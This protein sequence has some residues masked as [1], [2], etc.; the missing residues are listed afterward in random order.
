MNRKAVA[1]SP[2]TAGTEEARPPDAARERQRAS[3]SR[4]RV[5]RRLAARLKA[6]R[7][8]RTV[9][10]AVALVPLALLLVPAVWLVHHVYFDRTGVPD[11]ES[12]LRFEPPT[13]GV[14]RDARGE[15]LIE[16]AREYRRVVTYDEVP[17][18]LRQAIL[19]AED[20]RFFTHSGVDYRALPRV[21]QKTVVRSV[22]EWRKGGHGLRLLLPQ[23]GSTLTQQLVRGYFLQDL[24]GRLNGDALFHAGLAPPRL[25]SVV[26]GA[27]AT[28]KLLRKLEEVRLTL[29]L[30]EEMRRR[31][32]SQGQ[33][34]REIFARY[35]S[36]I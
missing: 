10:L 34:K 13:I 16:L 30:E 12:F 11:L 35:A 26:L 9:L 5:A 32:G 4:L 18:I 6:M 31:Y 29:W 8:R 27:S 7:R 3:F 23:G 20:K 1:L 15:V 24:T 14:V 17:L 28:N 22:A 25:L 36:F 21:V 2:Q 33:A 19:A